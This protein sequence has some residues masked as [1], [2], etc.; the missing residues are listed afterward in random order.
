MNLDKNKLKEELKLKNIMQV[1]RPLKVTVNVGVKEA[2]TDKKVLEAVSSQLAIITGQK[3]AVRKAKKSIATFKLRAGEPIGVMVTLHGKRMQDFINKLVT[4]VFPRVRDFHG[5]P[6][7]SLDG[8][9]NLSLGFAE[10][11]VFSEIEYDKIDRIRGLEVTITTTAKNN[12]EGLA[13]F[14]ALGFPFEKN[15]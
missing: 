5:I 7:K 2:I 13:L 8:Q 11:I 3:P 12:R 4:I 9:G 14:K 15:G 6:I 10:Q 1:P